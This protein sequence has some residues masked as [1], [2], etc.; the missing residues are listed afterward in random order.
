MTRSYFDS[1]ADTFRLLG[2]KNDFDLFFYKKNK[3]SE[4]R[5]KKNSLENV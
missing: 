3:I 1:K 5:G 2:M 4:E